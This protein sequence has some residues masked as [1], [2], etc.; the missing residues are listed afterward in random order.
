MSTTAV[1]TGSR[2]LRAAVVG[3][4]WGQVHVHALREHGVDVV[5]L[6]GAPEDGERTRAVAA[7]LGIPRAVHDPAHLLD[8]APDLVTVATPAATHPRL[9]TLFAGLPTICEKPL[10]GM[11]GSPDGL[12]A[13][14]PHRWI[15]YAFAFLDSARGAAR[16]LE[17][18]GE[19]RE[20]R[21][22][23]AHDLALTF[24]HPQWLLE[25]ASHP[26]SFV[27]HLLGRPTPV[28]GTLLPGGGTRLELLAG[29][30]EVTVECRPERGLHG[31]RHRLRL[32][33]E[34]GTVEL[35]GDFREG[36]VWGY[37]PVLRDGRAVGPAERPGSDVWV[38]ANVRAIGTAVGV[39]RGEL[40]AEEAVAA[41]LF[42]PERARPLDDCVRQAFGS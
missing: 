11:D 23:S 25:V 7:S 2:P 5:A 26:L 3:T 39:L 28:A 32:V 21:I 10:L 42:T 24:S 1:T 12:P 16:A 35:D 4:G 6:C 30:A 29:P 34:G 41:G 17:G 18:L 9:L 14:G 31:I 8:D 38:R 20:V 15:N 27:V 13:P 40:D 19:V 22:D 33:A 37:G 36:G